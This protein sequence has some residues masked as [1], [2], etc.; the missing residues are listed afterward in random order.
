MLG[1]DEQSIWDHLEE[2]ANRL[3]RVL[4]AV[5]VATIGIVALPSDVARVMR[6]DFSNYR[7][8]LSTVM[9]VI[10]DSLLP[11]G[12]NLI[13]FNWLDPFYIYFIV[14]MALGTIVTLPYLAYEL[15]KFI[16]P[17]LYPHER[18]TVYTFVIIA[19]VLFSVGV[20]YAWFI[21]LPTTFNVLYRFVYQS[22]VLPFFSVRDFF[23]MVA[24]G[25]IGSGLFYTFPIVI[26]ML[27]MADLIEVKTLKDNRKQLF[28]GLIIVTA[29]LTPDPTP[30]SMLLMSIPFYILYELTIQVLGRIKKEPVDKVFE[31]GL[32]ASRELLARSQTK[33][34]EREEQPA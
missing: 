31:S 4:F 32:R 6:L 5:V 24:F 28:V 1:D 3:R 17:A 12:V 11:K 34:I 7:P 19:S 25:L 23:N 14:A 33:D 21:L 13:A 29:I 16:S 2:L 15:F 8:L 20:A 30:F 27:V 22:R 9:E 26:W 10:Q 18:R